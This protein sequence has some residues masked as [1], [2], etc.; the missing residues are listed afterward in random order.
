M[1]KTCLTIAVTA[2]LVL[3]GSARASPTLNTILGDPAPSIHHTGQDFASLVD[4]EKGSVATLLLEAAGFRNSNVFGIYNPGDAS[5]KL[6][7]FAGADAPVDSVEV[8]FDLGAG[9]ATNNI[10]GLSAQ[11]GPV[12]GFYLISPD[13]TFYS[14]ELL[15]DD[16]AEHA[17]LYNTQGY[18]GLI[19]GDPD[20]VIAFEDLRADSLYQDWDYNDMVVGV[21]NAVPVPAPGAILLS[22]I[23]LSVVGYLRTRRTL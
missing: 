18:T 23:G 22:V 21:T 5:Q 7:L 20:A 17:L 1:K 10:T 14:D 3:A 16:G 13:G 12:F 11:I 8:T 4:T 15:N 9:K 6:L 2:L 19:F